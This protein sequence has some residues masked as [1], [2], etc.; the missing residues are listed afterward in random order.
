MYELGMTTADR[1]ME[2]SSCGNHWSVINENS[3]EHRTSTGLVVDQKVQIVSPNWH[4]GKASV[5]TGKN[6]SRSAISINSFDRNKQYNVVDESFPSFAKSNISVYALPVGLLMACLIVV[7]NLNIDNQLL[8][9]TVAQ[10]PLVDPIVT[11]G[12]EKGTKKRK[13]KLQFFKLK[14]YK[15]QKGSSSF[16]QVHGVARNVSDKIL[17]D[18]NLDIFAKNARGE[19]VLNWPYKIKRKNVQPG[20]EVKFV[21]EVADN[22]Q[23]ISSVTV[24]LKP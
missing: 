16:I 22:S 1:P 9:T 2:C 8:Q 3:I 14:F 24:R 5:Q 17:N 7:P 11:A 18:P 4:G 23:A 12:I 20:M 15:I 6:F 13:T 21:S 10:T 19:T